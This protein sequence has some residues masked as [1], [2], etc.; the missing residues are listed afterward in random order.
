MKLTP[1]NGS[2]GESGV[3]RTIHNDQP[4]Q[5]L[6]KLSKL[7]ATAESSI[8]NRDALQIRNRSLLKNMQAFAHYRFIQ[9]TSWS[10]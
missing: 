7:H 1:G 6:E 2:V 8:A 5:E 10:P 9:R 4:S 3:A